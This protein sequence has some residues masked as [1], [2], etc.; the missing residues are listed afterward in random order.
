[1]MVSDFEER[2]ID[3]YDWVQTKPNPK[4]P[5]KPMHWYVAKNRIKRIDEDLFDQFKQFISTDGD[6]LFFQGRKFM[7]LTVGEYRYWSVRDVINRELV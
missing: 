2:F 5:D 6:P 3:K 4:K 1:M 7:Y